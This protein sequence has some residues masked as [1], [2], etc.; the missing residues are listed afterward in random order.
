LY[1]L[2]FENFFLLFSSPTFNH[3]LLRDGLKFLLSY[4][5]RKEY[6]AFSA[7]GA[8]H[9]S[10]GQRQNVVAIGWYEAGPLAL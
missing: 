8:F 10:L 6:L 9:T 5:W 1:N 7:K 2:I 3:T 4:Q